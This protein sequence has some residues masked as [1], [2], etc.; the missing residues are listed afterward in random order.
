MPSNPAKVGALIF[1]F[2]AFEDSTGESIVQPVLSWGANAETGVTSGNVWYLT[3]WYGND[4]TYYVSKSA[5]VNPP[6]TVTGEIQRGLCVSLSTGCQWTITTSVGSTS[7]SLVWPAG[8]EM[9]QVFGGVMEVPWGSGCVET[10]PTGHEAFRNLVVNDSSGSSTPPIQPFKNVA[11]QC[12]VTAAPS[13]GI[14]TDIT[15]AP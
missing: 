1:F 9:T 13:S 8:P 11:P 6:G 2:P 4:G 12:S 14:N 15:W 3:S 5:H 10:P 7:V